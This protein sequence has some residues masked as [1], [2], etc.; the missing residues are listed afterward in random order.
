MLF[1]LKMTFLSFVVQLKLKV[2]TYAFVNCD[3]CGVE[4]VIT[5]LFV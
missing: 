2:N 5:S 4:V 3:A 1:T